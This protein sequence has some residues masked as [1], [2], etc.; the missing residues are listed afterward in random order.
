[1]DE[2]VTVEPAPTQASRWE[3]YI[4]VFFSPVELFR[5]RAADRVAPPLITLLILGVLA[6]LA[7]LPANAMMMRAAMAD[8]PEVAD[9]MGQLGLVIQLVGAVVVP[10]TYAVVVAIA[11]L[12]LFIVGRFV[13][14]RTEFSRTM[15]IATYAGFI[16]LLSQ[17]A[18]G[19]AILLHGEAGLDVM[20]HTSFGP[21]RFIDA[22]DMNAVAR[23][24]LQRLD[25]FAIWQT[26]LWGIGIAVIYKA[27]R[28][29]AAITAAATWILFAIPGII[30]AALGIGAGA[31]GG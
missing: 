14:L 17:I 22:T 10:I 8:N 31:A 23:A 28:A 24:L 18:T 30:G 27:S 7:M 15:L 19:G 12:L 21:L 3:D 29:Q 6:Y 11:A 25:I 4:D 2:A 9:A 5:R 16:Y 1:M 13:E 20:R 26:V